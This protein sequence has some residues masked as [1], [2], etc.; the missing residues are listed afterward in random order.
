[1]PMEIKAA[2]MEVVKI[3]SQLKEENKIQDADHRAIIDATAYLLEYFS[4]NFA[5]LRLREEVPKVLESMCDKYE[6]IGM[7]KGM[8]KGK[9]EA[10]QKTAQ[11][12]LKSGSP[13]DF[14][15]HVTELP[16]ETVEKLRKETEN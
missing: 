8:Q 15:C 5:D 10:L 13:V 16:K 4:M 1:M 2:T 3:A 6:N 9:E 14:V 12:M 11:R 7:Q